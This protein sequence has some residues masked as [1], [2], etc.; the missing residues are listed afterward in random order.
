MELENIISGEVSQVQ[1]AKKKKKERNKTGHTKG[2]SHTTGRG[3][4]KRKLRR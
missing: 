3:I 2:R 1:K 4:R